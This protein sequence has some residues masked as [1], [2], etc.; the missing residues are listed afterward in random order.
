MKT[1]VKNILLLVFAAC[2]GM[3]VFIGCAASPDK[4]TDESAQNREYMAQVNSL[5]DELNTGLLDF[6]DAV[7]ADD[8]VGMKTHSEKAYKAID[9]LEKVEAPEALEKVHQEY[10][11]GCKALKKALSGYIDLYSNIDTATED[12]PYDFDNY[13]KDLTKLKDDYNSGIDHLKEGDRLAAEIE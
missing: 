1:K 12:Q 2:I 10:L 5:M 6:S 9:D 3:S 4:A 13:N 7:S 8:L 11:D